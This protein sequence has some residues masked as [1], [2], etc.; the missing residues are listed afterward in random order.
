MIP[1]ESAIARGR[2]RRG[3]FRSPAVNVSTLKPRKAKNVS[4][5]LAMIFDADG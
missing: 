4:A 5:T 1:S 2:S 3:F